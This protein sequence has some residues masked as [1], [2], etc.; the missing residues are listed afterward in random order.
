MPSSTADLSDRFGDALEYCD[1]PLQQYGGVRSFSGP[2]T[3]VQCFQDI[4]LLRTLVQT[5]GAGGVLV[6][7]GG[8]SRHVALLG[9][10]MAQFAIDAGWAGVVINGVVRDVAALAGMP[11]GIKALGVSPR[12]GSR[13]GEG[14][15]DVPVTFGGAVFRPGRLLTSDDDGVVVARPRAAQLLASP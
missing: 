5:P 4:G 1:L 13:T 7:D 8:G 3:T 15:R 14:A 12:R 2:I 11:L 10:S 6:V 9:D